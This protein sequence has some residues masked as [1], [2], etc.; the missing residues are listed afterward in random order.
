MTYQNV[1]AGVRF[2]L[3]RQASSA[4]TT[5]TLIAVATSKDFSRDLKFEEASVVDSANPDNVPV[6]KSVPVMETFDVN[7]SGKADFAIFRAVLEAD[8]EAKLPVGY[9]MKIDEV[10]AKGGGQYVGQ[11]YVESL[12]LST[13]N[14]GIA[15]FTAKLRGEGPVTF[16]AASA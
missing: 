15:D 13:S 8:Y 6:R 11:Y 3:R 12:K 9:I 4:D 10:P 7:I 1:H 5:G 2:Q 16:T 14:N